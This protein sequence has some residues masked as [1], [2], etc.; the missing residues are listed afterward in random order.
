MIKTD[1]HLYTLTRG[2]FAKEI[3]KSTDC[4][5]KNMKRG[6]YKDLYIFKNNQYLF[7]SREAVREIQGMYPVKVYPV[8]R[9]I[10]RGGH[11]EAV[12]KGRYPNQHFANHNHMKKM[13]ALRG[14]LTPEELALVPQLEI[15][16]R[17][18][19]RRQVQEEVTTHRDNT[20]RNTRSH[21]T[22]YHP[23]YGGFVNVNDHRYTAN[24]YGKFSDDE[25]PY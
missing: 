17:E 22:M 2:E 14:K 6:K 15:K 8:K 13:I 7:K 25:G 19:R 3:G 16:A 18:E 5:K 24:N 20:L 10:N 23:K 9:K 21:N 12:R 1:D 11:E 4:V